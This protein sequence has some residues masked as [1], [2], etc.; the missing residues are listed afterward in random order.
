M[1]TIVESAGTSGRQVLVKYDDG[2]ILL[3][4]RDY[5]S[6]YD[7]YI[8]PSNDN[9]IDLNELRNHVNERGIYEFSDSSGG[10][11]DI[12]TLN[13]NNNQV[14]LTRD[15]GTTY[16]ID[17]DHIEVYEDYGPGGNDNTIDI[18][19][20]PQNIGN[21]GIVE[22]V[23][24]S[25]GSFE[26]VPASGQYRDQINVVKDDGTVLHVG[27]GDFYNSVLDGDS[28]GVVDLASVVAD[29]TEGI[30]EFY[31]SS[32]GNFNIAKSPSSD[33]DIFIARDDGT[34][35][36]IDVD[37]LNTYDDRDST[38]HDNRIDIDA[39]ADNAGSAKTY[40][41]YDSTGGKFTLI[42]LNGEQNMFAL[43]RDDG[44]AFLIDGDQIGAY[45]DY[46]G[47]Q[48][49]GRIDVSEFIN[50]VNSDGIYQ[51]VD[52]SGGSFKIVGG[53]DDTDYDDIHFA[54]ENGEL[55][56]VRYDTI[57][58]D[59]DRLAGDANDNVI[60]LQN[61]SDNVDDMGSGYKYNATVENVICF[62]RHTRISTERGE[63]P[64]EELRVGDK[65]ITRDCGFQ[66]IRWIGSTKCKAE[67][68]VAPILFREGTV[69]NDRELIVSPNHRM[70]LRSVEAELYTGESENLVPAKYMVDGEG[71]VRVLGGM[72]EYF[73]I[74][75]DTHQIVRSE[76]SWTES[77]HP[78]RMG[79][80]SLCEQSR[81]EILELFPELAIGFSNVDPQTARQVL[82][83]HEA[84]VVLDAMNTRAL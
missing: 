2:T 75:F 38:A 83:R 1:S 52:S 3:I 76:G 63:V 60:D 24:S 70:L 43:Q 55:I 23:D 56:T 68:N 27:A 40:V 67:G 36:V 49:N 31:D 19:E 62:A 77:F 46:D 17:I 32:G 5:F 26:L 54:R 84:L 12:N 80:S 25:G 8:G 42:G 45:E 34:T 51:V 41:F 74:L 7:N 61:L 39:Q 4:D 16:L 79:W 48:N 30:W 66:E 22:V 14:V 53:A 6:S 82:R 78:G 33:N 10:D 44:T 9:E 58:S 81:A 65:V 11:F 73:H 50:K 37:E 18:S 57:E 71:V 35:L 21:D 72:V 15:D 20:I 64:V 69:G 28:D 29:G 59:M 13:S 47:E